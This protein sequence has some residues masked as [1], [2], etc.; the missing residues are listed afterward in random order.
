[1]SS[2]D[3][4]LII[5]KPSGVTSHDV[6]AQVRRV[7][8]TRQV[9]HAGTLDP[10]ATGVLVVAVG[11]ATRLLEFVVSDTKGY[12]AV[13]ELG[14][15]TDTD[16][17]TGAELKRS[18]SLPS[19]TEI[20]RALQQF[21]G[22]IQQ[23]PPNFSAIKQ[24]GQPV[25]KKARRGEA[26]EL[27]ARIVVITNIEIQKFASPLLSLRIECGSGTYIRSIARDL[28]ELLGCGGT[29]QSLRRWR[30]GNF[31]IDQAV[32]LDT[33]S[34]KS[35]QPVEYVLQWLPSMEVTKTG[36]DRL[37]QGLPL[38]GEKEK[39]E[40]LPFITYNGQIVAALRWKESRWWPRK[41]RPAS[42]QAEDSALE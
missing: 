36:Y 40:P 42:F 30:S 19:L 18:T 27:P 2:I 31:L 35:L 1:M 29:L 39:N 8:H 6:V 25:Y 13:I 23:R 9:G 26:V 37:L 24:G 12:D 33:L 38:P 41:V 34:E 28:G 16:D 14:L 21:R 32:S 10:M 5:D 20:E 3:G 4:F 11:W 15:Q 17:I 22:E 7:F